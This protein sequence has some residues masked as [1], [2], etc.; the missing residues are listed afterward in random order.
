MRILLLLNARFPTQKAYGIQ[1]ITMAEGYAALGHNVAIAFPRRSY[2]RPLPMAG[3]RCLPFGPL[4]Q[5]HAGWMFHLLRLLGVWSALSV[6]RDFNPDVVIANDLLQTAVLSKHWPTVW[7][8]HDVPDIRRFG[9]TRLIRRSASRVRGIVSTN[10]LKLDELHK[11]VPKLPPHI[12]APNAVTFEPDVYRHIDREEARRRL[13]IPIDELALVYAGQLFDWKGV[14]TLIESAAH[15]PSNVVIHIVGGS[16]SDLERCRNIAAHI[17][18]DRA[19]VVFHGQRPAE[20]IP[21]W[22]RA[23]TL[24]VIPNSARF[25][26]SVRDTSPLKLFEALAAGAAIVA[27][28]LPSI[29]EATG[30]STAIAYV[31]ADDPS[32]LARAA[33]SLIANPSAIESMRRSAEQFPVLTGV[34]RARRIVEFLRGI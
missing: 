31:R 9:R 4:L 22:L 5:I 20:E 33:S 21:T 6:I 18:T 2:E 28:D 17:P 10:A 3:V 15:L 7:E 16:G 30:S 23:A 24:I 12:V 13:L 25:A 14:D 27:S 19:R 29:R 34:E 8:L 32:S 1:T 11:L 26:V